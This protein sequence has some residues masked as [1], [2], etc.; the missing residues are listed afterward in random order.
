MDLDA[1]Q[2]ALHTLIELDPDTPTSSDDDYTIRTRLA[3]KWIKAWENEDG[4]LWNELWK[5]GSIA[6]T[7]ASNY[8]LSSFSMTDFKRPGG[9]IYDDKNNYYSVIELPEVHLMVPNTNSQYCYFL[10]NINAFTLYFGSLYPASGQTIYI[11]YFKTASSLSTGTDKPEMSDPYYIVHGIA[12]DLLA[13]EDPAESDKHFQLT[14]NIM[15]NM[16]LRNLQVPPYQ[17]NQIPNRN[18]S[19]GIKGFGQ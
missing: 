14:Q 8:A 9:F 19:V 17:N 15:K 18:A 1:I 11:P 13:T 5:K 16:K 3:N 10:G 2:Q 7:G 6:S 4:M 12:A